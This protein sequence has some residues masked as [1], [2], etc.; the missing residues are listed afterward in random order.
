MRRAPGAVIASLALVL[1][2][3][4][5][6]ED[7]DLMHDEWI[8]GFYL[9]ETLDGFKERVGTSIAWTEIAGS[10]HDQRGTMLAITG[11]PSG[12]REIE[13][14]RLTFFEDRLMEI[15]FYYRRTTF[16]QLEMLRDM[17]AEKYG[18]EP[19]SPGGEI[20]MAYKT[21]WFNTPE[22]SITIRR[23]TKKPETELY[24]Q[25]QHRELVERLKEKR[26]T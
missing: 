8:E 12:T 3:S 18:V 10:P 5:S 26:G 25:Y 7:E 6:G 19:A 1:L 22:M 9:G 24:V 23:I 13:M 14:S 15:V 11:A 21:Y 2:V 16:S 4:C 20:E 17:I